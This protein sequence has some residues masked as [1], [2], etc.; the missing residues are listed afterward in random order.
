ML[1]EK[2]TLIEDLQFML[3]SPWFFINLKCLNSIQPQQI[4]YQMLN[5]SSKYFNQSLLNLYTKDLAFEGKPPHSHSGKF[6]RTRPTNFGKQM[7]SSRLCP[8][9]QMD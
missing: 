4:F 5:I 8:I 3:T 9:H 2:G 6:I 1:E 7:Q